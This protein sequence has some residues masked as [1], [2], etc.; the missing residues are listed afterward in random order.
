LRRLALLPFA[1]RKQERCLW[2]RFRQ[3]R[4]G[5]PY[6]SIMREGA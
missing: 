6:M 2:G 3:A 1:A 4:A 5:E